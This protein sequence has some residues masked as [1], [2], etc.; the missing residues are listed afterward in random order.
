MARYYDKCA[1]SSSNSKIVDTAH[2]VSVSHPSSTEDVAVAPCRL[3]HGAYDNAL[4]GVQS[5][6]KIVIN[7]ERREKL[8]EIA[9]DTW[10]PS[11]QRTLPERIRV[12]ASIEA[13]PSE[14]N[15]L[16]GLRLRRWPEALIA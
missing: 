10:L 5:D 1:Q 16:L 14:A 15:L 12:P 2:I 9:M 13:R 3:H 11:F 7:P 4:L 8:R 6:Y